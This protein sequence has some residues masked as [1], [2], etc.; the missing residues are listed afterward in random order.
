MTSSFLSLNAKPERAQAIGFK[1]E[2]KK[3]KVSLE[4][5]AD[6]PEGLKY[7]DIVVGNGK[8]VDRGAKVTAH[9]DC[10]YRGLDVVSTRSARLLGGNRTIAEPIEFIAGETLAALAAPKLDG[11]SPAGGLF[12]GASGPRPPPALSIAVLGMK[13][14]GKVGIFSAGSTILVFWKVLKRDFA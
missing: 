3:R 11:D 9:F 8:E 14:G 1:K 5:Y 4:E 12:S 2:L 10:L 6:G 13:A 7:F